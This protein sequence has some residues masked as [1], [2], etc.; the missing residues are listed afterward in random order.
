VINKEGL[1]FKTGD[2]PDINGDLDDFMKGFPV[3]VKYEVVAEMVVMNIYCFQ[4]VF[5]LF[6]CNNEYITHYF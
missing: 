4:F 3:G 5:S 6:L 1:E 2:N